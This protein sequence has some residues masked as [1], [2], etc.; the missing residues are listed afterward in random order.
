MPGRFRIER[1]GN[2]LTVCLLANPQAPVVT[3]ALIYRAGTR[4]EVS[5]HG[6]AAHF[7]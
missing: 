1:L 5:G 6:G 2:G 7:L 4:D 3:S